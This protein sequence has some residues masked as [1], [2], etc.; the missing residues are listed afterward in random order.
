ME[1]RKDNKIQVSEDGRVIEILGVKYYRSDLAAEMMKMHRNTL[2]EK[3]RQGK[4]RKYRHNHAVWFTEAW[5][6]AYM[7]RESR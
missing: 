7:D 5:M 2:L 3:A 6:R 4:I 1:G